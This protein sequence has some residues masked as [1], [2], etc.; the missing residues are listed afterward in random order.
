MAIKLGCQGNNVFYK[1]FR[2][3]HLIL[4]IKKYFHAPLQY[5]LGYSVIAYK[6]AVKFCRQVYQIKL[7]VY[8]YFKTKY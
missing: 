6:F 5:V 2:N 4:L 7:S 1:R 3:S 8:T